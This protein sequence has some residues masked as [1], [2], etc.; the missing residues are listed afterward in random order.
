MVGE[1]VALLMSDTPLEIEPDD[2]GAKLTVT[3]ALCPAASVKGKVMPLNENPFPFQFPD[4]IVIAELEAVICAVRVVLLPT[5]T[6]PKLVDEV[7]NKSVPG[8]LV[9]LVLGL[10]FIGDWPP[11]QPDSTAA[12][13]MTNA[14]EYRDITCPSSLHCPRKW[15]TCLD[16]TKT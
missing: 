16:L 14:R 3:E 9:P 12:T 1:F 15:E 5:A 13:S 7:E 10:L 2:C 8:V 11:P 4:E 6:L